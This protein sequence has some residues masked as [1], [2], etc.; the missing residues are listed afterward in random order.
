MAKLKCTNC[1][2][3]TNYETQVLT[4]KFSDLKVGM[5]VPIRCLFCRHEGMEVTELER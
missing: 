1:Q 2:K 3:T 4:R 5:V